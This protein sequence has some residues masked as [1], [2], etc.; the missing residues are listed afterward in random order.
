MLERLIAERWVRA[1][2]VVGLWPANALGDDIV[3]YADEQRGTTLAT[4][5]TLRQQLARDAS[6]PNHALADFVAPV[7]S[8]TPDYVGAFAVT[9]GHREAERSEQFERDNDD[10]G[11]ILFK[12]LCDRL[13]EAFAE[14]LHEWVRTRVMGLQSRGAFSNEELIAGR[15]R[16]IRPAPGYPCQ[17]DHT[18]K[19]TLFALLEAS[20]ARR[21][22]ADRQ[23]RDE[24]RILGFGHLLRPSAGALLRR[25][26]DRRRS[27]QGLRGAEGLDADGGATLA[28]ADPRRRRERHTRRRLSADARRPLACPWPPRRGRPI[29]GTRS[30]VNA[31]TP[32]PRR[33]L[34]WLCER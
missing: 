4:L 24:S 2:A 6:H 7:D 32:A 30:A 19:G 15:Y 8:G 5:H 31:R 11:A 25:R 23:L 33:K 1:D 3:V 21:D 17:P 22:H 12:A 16:G 9:T 29:I 14:R 10:Y 34:F 18:E 28:R 20:A 27:A 26:P 13:A